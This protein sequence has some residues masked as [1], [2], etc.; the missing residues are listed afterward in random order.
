V[1]GK[2]AVLSESEGGRENGG[3]KGCA[4]LWGMCKSVHLSEAVRKASSFSF[5]SF[6]SDFNQEQM[7]EQADELETSAATV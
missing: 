4:G 6:S 2:P 3:E 7:S 1:E 5:F